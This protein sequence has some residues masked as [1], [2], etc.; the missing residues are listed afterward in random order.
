[1]RVQIP[2]AS[3]DRNHSLVCHGYAESPAKALFRRDQVHLLV[4]NLVYS[5]LNNMADTVL[6][7]GKVILRGG[8]S[9]VFDEE[10]VI[11]RVR[12][13]QAGMIK[14]AGHEGEIGLTSSWP[15]ITP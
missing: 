1:V 12:E 5:G 13:A 8:R 15:V 9:T 3:S 11:A 14:E 7:G 6:V 10:E 4:N 2:P